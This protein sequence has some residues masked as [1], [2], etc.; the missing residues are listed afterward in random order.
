MH[1]NLLDVHKEDFNRKEKKITKFVT[2]M[3]YVIGVYHIVKIAI[4]MYYIFTCTPGYGE[5]KLATTNA[6][7]DL[8]ICDII[9]VTVCL[10][11]LLYVI[12]LLWKHSYASY[13][14]EFYKHRVFFII[15][16]ICMLTCMPS[17]LLESIY[18]SVDTSKW[19]ISSYTSGRI[20]LYV[21]YLLHTVPTL[22]FALFK[23]NEDCFNCFNRLAP[24][25]YSRYQYSVY[26]LLNLQLEV[27]EQAD[28]RR[29]YKTNLV[30]CSIA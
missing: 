24:Q 6:Y 7:D 11:Y 3:I 30:H 28:I 1:A 10:I 14:F 22:I 16:S 4:G 18:W 21:D 15:F 19:T 8:L 29:R 13:R 23:P 26:D 9:C 5:C 20:L 12:V 2:Y 25:R 27:E 17:I